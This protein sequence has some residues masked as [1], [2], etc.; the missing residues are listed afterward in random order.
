M[1]WCGN[2]AMPIWWVSRWLQHHMG[3]DLCPDIEVPELGAVM[4]FGTPERGD[5]CIWGERTGDQIDIG[6]PFAWL[7]RFF[8]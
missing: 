5:I 6:S 8:M 3:L 7:I 1:N 4:H 2:F